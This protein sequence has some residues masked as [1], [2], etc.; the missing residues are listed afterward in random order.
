MTPAPRHQTIAINARY[1]SPQTIHNLG[2]WGRY[3][4]TTL[5]AN[6]AATRPHCATGWKFLPAQA[7]LRVLKLQGRQSL[8]L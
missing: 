8:R 3:R 6:P 4:A 7:A 1:F 2:T 5:S